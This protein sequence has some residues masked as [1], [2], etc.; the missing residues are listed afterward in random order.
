MMMFEIETSHKIFLLMYILCG[1]MISVPLIKIRGVTD[2][3]VKLDW[4]PP[5]ASTELV[6][7]SNYNNLIY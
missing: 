5:N 2:K 4:V 7:N 1:F 6:S 3:P